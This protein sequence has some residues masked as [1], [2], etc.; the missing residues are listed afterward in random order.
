MLLVK[1]KLKFSDID[2]IG[3]F[4]NQFI[5][6]GTVIWKYETTIDNLYRVDELRYIPEIA[7]KMLNHY[8]YRNEYGDYILCGDDARFFN[9]SSTPNCLEE[10]SPGGTSPTIALRDIE[11]DEELTVN[12]STFDND[13]KNKLNVK[14]KKNRQSKRAR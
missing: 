3:L 8:G 5:P 13:Y 1:T 6:K 12:Y 9:H 10:Y 7:K 2:G 14:K 11:K 4:S